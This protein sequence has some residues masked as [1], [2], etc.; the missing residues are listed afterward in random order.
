MDQLLN[1]PADQAARLR[2]RQQLDHSVICLAGAGAGKTH[3]LVERM[4]ACIRHGTC[5]VEELAAITFT[6]KAAGELRARFYQQ[7]QSAQLEAERQHELG[8]DELPP[9]NL[10]PDELQT[11]EMSTDGDRSE[12]RRLQRAVRHLDR[13]KIGTIHAF[14]ARLLRQY[15]ARARLPAD[16]HE[17]EE[18]EELWLAR[19]AWD[20]FLEA[21]S[22]DGDRRLQAI[23]DTGLTAEQFYQF[24]LTRNQYSDLPLKPTTQARPD[25]EGPT[26]QLCEFVH[27]VAQ[28]IPEDLPGE[29]DRLMETVT[30]LQ[31]RFAFAAP[32][33]DADRA[34]LLR[35]FDSSAATQVTLKRWGPPGS[36]EQHLARSLRDSLT[37]A[38]RTQVIQPVLAA[39]RRYVYSLAAEFV[40]EAT[41]HYRQL[42]RRRGM[43]T[44]NDLME[45]TA[46][47]LRDDLETRRSLQQ[48][49]RI[50]FV[51]EFQDTDPLQAQILLYLTG[52]E[53]TERSWQ[54][55]T[56]RPGSLFLVGDE[57]QS[58]Y[59]FRRADVDVF[60]HVTQRL[61]AGG[62]AP[63]EL[64]ST[65]RASPRL[66]RWFN[67]TFEG[68][69][70][71]QDL[72]F[73]ASFRRLHAQRQ[74]VAGGGVFRLRSDQPKK[75]RQALVEAEAEKVAR[76]ISA[77]I[78]G[79]TSLNGEDAVLG[80]GAEPGD[81]MILT[82]TR[83]WLANYG[84]ALERCGLPYDIT[85][86]GS[87]RTSG[88]LRALVDA[89]DSVLR[90]DDAIAL[91]A[92]LRGLLFGLG[93][94]ELYVLRQA[95]WRFQLEDPIPTD[96]DPSIRQRT[97]RAIDQLLRLRHD[98]HI[99]PPAAALERFVD[100]SGLAAVAAAEEGGSA[101]AGNLLR[102]LAMVRDWQSRRGLGWV[103]IGNELR[104][105]LEA[106]EFRIEEMTLETG[107]QD[108]VRIMN[109][110][111]AKG[112]EAK[113]VFLVDPTDTSAE[114]H[115]VD[116]HVSRLGEQPYLSMAVTSQAGRK[117]WVMAEPDGWAEDEQLEE[118]YLA[119]EQLR[120][121][122]VA[123]TRAADVLVVGQGPTHSGPWKSLH[124]G[125]R[126]VE[127][128][129]IPTDA[130]RAVV[131]DAEGRGAVDLAKT[132]QRRQDGWQQAARSSWEQ[133][134]VSD[135][136]LWPDSRPISQLDSHPDSGP[137]N[138]S[139]LEWGPDLEHHGREY[140]RVVH[141]LFE[142]CIRGLLP[143]GKEQ[144]IETLASSLLMEQG[145]AGEQFVAH[146][147]KAVKDFTNS[148]LWEQIQASTQVHC[149]V[150]Y[151]NATVSKT[152]KRIERGVI[153]LVFGTETG[154]R[155]VDYKTQPLRIDADG[156]PTDESASAMLK[157]YEHQLSAYV[158]HWE[159]VTGQQ[160]SGGLWLTAHACW[161]P[162]RVDDRKANTR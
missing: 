22:A 56:P 144:T 1:E 55:Q 5:Q 126:D 84:R 17:V 156:T 72:R 66:A 153:D 73:Q 138:A 113:V 65:F 157:R 14:C 70:E 28:Q 89:L 15:P 34:F 44:F 94:D 31:H 117:P 60:R 135:A 25:L 10:S 32:Q 75:N 23:E 142:Q 76:F 92:V 85:G 98:L 93:D 41:L 127:D 129:P 147:V 161:L 133:I 37:K 152:G 119:A 107:R 12:A 69:F 146:A 121:V 74:D 50:I 64:T 123:A 96:L 143:T 103:E 9:D 21:P 49:F 2:I 68:L 62:G 116:V 36:P 80:P 118:R 40:E 149:E 155:L 48:R 114:R 105:L 140:G 110:H 100:E 53:L 58:I 86:P 99:R 63:I 125:L 51:D 35:T 162:A 97:T 124:L 16:F 43:L 71:S 79:E 151:A 3:E 13:C 159:Q 42:R 106:D 29:P 7:L 38:L 148:P 141:R 8:L 30:R 134:T 4:V 27:Q 122:Y 154:W 132:R 19:Q 18:R 52:Q 112:L 137:G 81:F 111:Q 128:L 20:Q 67:D 90:A 101:R 33:T 108:V 150:P 115:G 136:E 11:D 46:T 24:F 57:K 59:R 139:E 6:R 158:T 120:L 39:W 131:G 61:E 83:R 45:T 91:V 78:A 109:L 88:E 26:Q 82:R 95:G 104:D 47:M 160:V 87:L 145:V 102:V 130:P 77:A 54:G